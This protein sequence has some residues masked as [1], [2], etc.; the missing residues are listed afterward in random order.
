M[1]ELQMS[2]Y[3]GVWMMVCVCCGAFRLLL[4][5]EESTALSRS[6]QSRLLLSLN[7]EGTSS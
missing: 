2:T 1:M 4:W 6:G 3:D 7:C 5:K